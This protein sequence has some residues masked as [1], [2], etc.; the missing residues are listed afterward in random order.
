MEL[1]RRIDMLSGKL[2][3]YQDSEKNEKIRQMAW[4][5]NTME[6]D[7]KKLEEMFWPTPDEI[8]RNNKLNKAARKWLRDFRI[9]FIQEREI[10]Y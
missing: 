6:E 4:I 1:H 10:G 2:N 8:K 3:L 5:T 7:P 9:A